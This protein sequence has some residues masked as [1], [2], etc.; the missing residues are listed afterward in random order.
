MSITPVD[1]VWSS[2]FSEF[3]KWCNYLCT[4]WNVTSVEINHSQQSSTCFLCFW[5]VSV[6]W[7]L[8]LAWRGP[9]KV[10]GVVGEVDYRIPNLNGSEYSGASEHDSVRNFPFA[11]LR[12][13]TFGERPRQAAD[14]HLLLLAG[15][16]HRCSVDR[17]GALRVCLRCVGIF[18]WKDWLSAESG[19]RHDHLA[20]NIP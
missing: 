20:E 6:S 1:H 15:S 14:A 13:T 8:T 19:T 3:G 16:Q 12:T 10:V 17:A 7:Q 2:T 4:I 18:E 9:Y 5:S 11:A